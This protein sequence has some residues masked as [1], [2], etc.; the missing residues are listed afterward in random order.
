M[1]QFVFLLIC[2]L[3]S[4]CNASI[5]T[6]SGTNSLNGIWIPLR[7]ELAGKSLP[8]SIF[9]S[10]KLTLHDS[11]YT[12]VAES[13]DNGIVRCSKGRMDIYGKEGVNAGKHFT[14]IY[15]LENGQLT[16]CYNLTGDGFPDSFETKDKQTFF[17]SVFKMELMK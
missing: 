3:I 14:A 2:F 11:N 4:S 5:E 13:K 17:L 15:K 9:E 12:Y 10:Q 7:Q 8:A 6:T 1:R 16:I